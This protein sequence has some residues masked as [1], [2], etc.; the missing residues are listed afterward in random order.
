MPFCPHNGPFWF[1]HILKSFPKNDFADPMQ[2]QCSHDKMSFL[3]LCRYDRHATPLDNELTLNS[4]A[5]SDSQMEPIFPMDFLCIKQ[6]PPRAIT[7]DHSGIREMVKVHSTWTKVYHLP[8]DMSILSTRSVFQRV[9]W[10]CRVRIPLDRSPPGQHNPL[11][12]DMSMHSLRE[13]ITPTFICLLQVQMARAV[14]TVLSILRNHHTWTRKTWT[15]SHHSQER[16]F[17]EIPSSTEILL[18][19]LLHTC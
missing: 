15:I 7:V 8:V 4:V 19:A 12:T 1:V 13:C 9:L 18:P 3:V 11:P 6:N 2:S 17:Q 5:P 14:H 16:I 10:R